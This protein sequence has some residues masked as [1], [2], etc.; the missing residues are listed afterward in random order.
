MSSLP[1]TL[2]RS[3]AHSYHILIIAHRDAFRLLDVTLWPLV[4]F[5][6]MTLFA[7][8]FTQDR[9]VTGV[10]VLG[11]LDKA[12]EVLRQNAAIGWMMLTMVEGITRGEGGIGVMLLNE[13]KHFRL[14]DVFAIQIVILGIG[15]L[16]DYAIGLMRQIVCPYA[17]LTMERQD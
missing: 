8:S 5:L 9:S 1:A 11:T 13:S 6:S 3:L 4:L 17:D 16:Q 12:F 10:V 7:G 15:L 14:S 2:R